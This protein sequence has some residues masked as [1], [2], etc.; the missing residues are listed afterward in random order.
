MQDER[1]R[2]AGCAEGG[3][4]TCLPGSPQLRLL[5]AGCPE[6]MSARAYSVINHWLKAC[7]GEQCGQPRPMNVRL[8]SGV[9]PRVWRAGDGARGSV[10]CAVSVLFRGKDST[11]N[12]TAPRLAVQQRHGNDEDTNPT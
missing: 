9:A 11:D 7:G 4:A 5:L 3:G 2:A 6:P 8:A 12:Y 1:E 10:W